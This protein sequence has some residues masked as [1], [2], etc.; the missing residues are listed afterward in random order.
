MLVFDGIIIVN[1]FLTAFFI[2][3]DIP[4]CVLFSLE[5]ILKLYTYGPLLYFS[6]LLNW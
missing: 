3:M 1:V 6:H 2:D 5:I 4:F